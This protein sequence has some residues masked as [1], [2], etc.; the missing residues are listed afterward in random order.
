MAIVYFTEQGGKVAKEGSSLFLKKDK[1]VLV[2]IPIKNLEALVV[3]GR[4]S[5]TPQAIDLLLIEAVPVS[6]LSIRG[7]LKGSLRPVGTK[8]VPLKIKQVKS[9]SDEGRKKQWVRSLIEAKISNSCEVIEGF[10]KNHGQ[11]PNLKNASRKIKSIAERLYNVNEIEK[12]RAIEGE[13]ARYYFEALPRMCKGELEFRGRSR[14]PPHDPMNSLISFAYALITAEIVALLFGVGIDP[15]IGLY[16]EVR[17]GRPSMA[18][19]VLEEF[20]HPIADKLAIYINNNRI[21]KNN[22]F[23]KGDKNSVTMTDEARKKFLH[24][25]EKRMTAP[26]HKEESKAKSFRDILKRQAERARRFIEKDE[27]YCPFTMKNMNGT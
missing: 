25:Y 17:Y 23:Q 11:D 3:F 21:L 9:Y 19:D 26:L 16:H 5:F 4:I 27:E 20:R 15:D 6:L 14:R 24:E 22:D 18:L 12:M 13:A 1:D 2:R 7:R 10:R 8:N